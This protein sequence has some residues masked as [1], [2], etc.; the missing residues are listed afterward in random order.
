[1]KGFDISKLSTSS[2]ATPAEGFDISKIKTAG[3]PI[4]TEQ[5]LTGEYMTEQPV[6]APANAEI[7]KNEYVKDPSGAIS[8]AEGEKHEKGGIKVNLEDG[9][10]ILSDSLKLSSANVKYLSRVFDIDLS[11]KDTYAKAVDKYT[12]K[13]GLA[14]LNS[15]QEDLFATMK[16][17]I[18]KVATDP[19]TKKLNND[20]L[21]AKIYEVEKKKEPLKQERKRF[22]DYLFDL[23]EASKP[24]EATNQHFKYGGVSKE[25]F[26]GMLQKHGITY[27]EGIKMLGKMPKFG[28]GGTWYEKMLEYESEKGM[29]DGTGHPN[30]GYNSEFVQ[31]YKVNVPKTLEEAKQVFE[32]TILPKVKDYPAGV[33]EQMG[34]FLFN[35]GKDA[36][37]YLLAERGQITPAQR[38]AFKDAMKDGEWTDKA[39]EKEF[40]ALW[41]KSGIDLKKAQP[42]DIADL[43]RGR[44]F[45]YKNTNASNGKPNPAYDKTWKGRVSLYDADATSNNNKPSA[46]KTA[47]IDP[48]FN[49]DEALSKKWAN[50]PEAYA[51]FKKTADF[52]KGEK[53]ADFRKKMYEQYK[54][55]IE[56]NTNYT[57]G[58][59]DA[60][61]KDL[62][63]IKDENELVDQ[64]L[65][66]EERNSRLAAHG[67]DPKTVGNRI[68]KGQY[69]SQPVLDFIDKNKEG[70]GDIKFDKGHIG[71]AAYISYM[72][73]VQPGKLKGYKQ[74]QVGVD[75]ELKKFSGLV[76]GIDANSVDTTLGEFIG[77]NIPEPAEPA[78]K[79]APKTGGAEPITNKVNPYVRPKNPKF[80][81]QPD[82]F[83]LPPNAQ[84][85]ETM[86]QNR[87]G[88]VDPIRIGIENNLQAQANVRQETSKQLESLPPSQRAAAL[89]NIL[90]TSGEQENQAIFQTNVANAQN[91]SN[92]EQFNIGQSDREDI[93]R[94]QNVLG[95]EQ[96]ALTA[97]D[98]TRQDLRNYLDFQSNKSVNNFQNQQ[99]L[100]LINGMFPDFE[101]DNYGM[102][103]NY[104]PSRQWSVEERDKM[105]RMNMPAYTSPVA[106]NN[107]NT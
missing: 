3:Q 73:T 105:L 37:I 100:N 98:K 76:S 11:T 79:E 85:P 6:N 8:K 17:E 32:K 63:S 61:Y 54:Q 47:N 80:F 83:V 46:A 67:L 51:K 22:F 94:S 18:E 27:E 15:E 31:K 14:K 40:I 65:A 30:F 96:R 60:F 107:Q 41:D 7:E 95:Y 35:T 59:K 42:E 69:T 39:K 104:D 38:V 33:Q 50:K 106:T 66:Q 88:R 5:A 82:Q 2:K 21:S 10:E 68:A 75:D 89:A 84:S 23:Q 92:A 9:T 97:Q 13:I 48:I 12:K 77:A 70:L 43:K 16:K 57:R 45:Y 55:D 36:R 81:F 25:E 29:A 90:A 101:L 64:L 24:E 53:S 19:N 62:S 34:D 103:V 71:Q 52:L 44:D 93:A 86:V 26:E 78:A 4:S 1:M 49:G 102:A 56:D 58:K 74:E 20:Y 87:F 91:I 28:G 72:N 99:R